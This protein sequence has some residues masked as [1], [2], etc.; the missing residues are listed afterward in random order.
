MKVRKIGWKGEKT[1][2]EEEAHLH[3]DGNSVKEIDDSL[4]VRHF[5]ITD[6]DTGYV[7]GEITVAAQKLGNGI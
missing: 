5:R 4:F 7:D 1:E 3:K 6:N 2:Q